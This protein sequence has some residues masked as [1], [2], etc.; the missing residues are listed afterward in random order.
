MRGRGAAGE[1]LAEG[2][3]GEELLRGIG[4]VEC[5]PLLVGGGDLDFRVGGGGFGGEEVD[6][7]A[8]EEGDGGIGGGLEVGDEGVVMPEALAVQGLE[9]ALVEGVGWPEC[10]ECGGGGVVVEEAGVEEGNGCAAGGESPT[11]G[12]ADNSAADDDDVHG[13]GVRGGWLFSWPEKSCARATAKRG[14]DGTR[15]L[16]ETESQRW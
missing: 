6:A 15:G 10:A 11:A 14:L 7:A 3:G 4:R 13:E 8:A 2:F 9:R 16:L 1:D 12:E 5:G